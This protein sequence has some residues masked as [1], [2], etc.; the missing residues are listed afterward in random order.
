LHIPANVYVMRV[1]RATD[2]P[3]KSL[4]GGTRGC[5]AFT[6]PPPRRHFASPA[7]DVLPYPLGRLLPVQF[8]LISDETTVR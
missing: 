5:H 2:V 7:G 6:G 4:T 8:F 1:G 3:A